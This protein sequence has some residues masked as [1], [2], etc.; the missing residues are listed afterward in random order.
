MGESRWAAPV[1]VSRC[2][3][4]GGG[5]WGADGAARRPAVWPAGSLLAAL[6]WADQL[7]VEEEQDLPLPHVCEKLRSGRPQVARH[8]G[9]QRE[10]AH[11]PALQ[12]KVAT[13]RL[14]ESA[15]TLHEAP[16]SVRDARLGAPTSRPDRLGYKFEPLCDGCMWVYDIN[17]TTVG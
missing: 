15:V 12:P 11:G 10:S 7:R 14:W 3:A 6:E 13:G 5:V 8:R 1:G 16:P 2:G 4:Q 17:T 9:L